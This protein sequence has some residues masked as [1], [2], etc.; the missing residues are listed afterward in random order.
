M[1]IALILIHIPCVV[2]LHL[3]G[4]QI[5]GGRI[6]RCSVSMCRVPYLARHCHESSSPDRCAE[7]RFAGRACV[8]R[9]FAGTA[10]QQQVRPIWRR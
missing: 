10:A 4:I 9:V 5:L 7:L 3:D 8:R 6:K 2:G 1:S